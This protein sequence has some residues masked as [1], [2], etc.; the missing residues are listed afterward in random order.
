MQEVYHPP[1]HL[2]DTAHIAGFDHYK[3]LYQE[4]IENPEKFW[5]K[6]SEQI[7]FKISFRSVLYIAYIYHN[8]FYTSGIAFICLLTSGCRPNTNRYFY[9]FI[10]PLNHLFLG[11][12]LMTKSSKGN[13]NYYTAICRHNNNYL[14]LITQRLYY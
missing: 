10:R 11:S 2:S 14:F 5:D 8:I 13:N 6:V 3:K 9:L 4:S 1:K 12:V 7:G